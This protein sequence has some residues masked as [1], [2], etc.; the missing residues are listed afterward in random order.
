MSPAE[1]IALAGIVLSA[2]LGYLGYRTGKE[3]RVDAR[4]LERDRWAR[5]DRHRNRDDKVAAFAA[6]LAAMEEK[7]DALIGDMNVAEAG[8]TREHDA[9]YDD[10]GIPLQTIIVLAPGPVARAAQELF[11]YSVKFGLD[12]MSK[13]VAV[14]GVKTQPAPWEPFDAEEY[15]RLR[16]ILIGAIHADLGIGG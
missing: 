6:F 15:H 4:E 9:E 14:L 3:A 1:G 8:G 13:Q 12:V 7:I 16:D 10:P 11:D 5:E 2:L